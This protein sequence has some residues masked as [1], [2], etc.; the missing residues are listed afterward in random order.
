MVRSGPPQAT[1]F[2]PTMLVMSASSRRIVTYCGIGGDSL[3][4][5]TQLSFYCPRVNAVICVR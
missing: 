3:L 1:H 4:L 2:F 5:T